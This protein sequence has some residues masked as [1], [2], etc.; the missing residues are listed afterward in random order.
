VRIIIIPGGTDSNGRRVD[1]FVVGDEHSIFAWCKIFVDQNPNATWPVFLCAT[2]E[3]QK[4][5]LTMLGAS[6]SNVPVVRPHLTEPDVDAD[7]T[8]EEL[9]EAIRIT[10]TK[11]DDK[12][13]YRIMNAVYQQLAER[14]RTGRIQ[15]KPVY[16]DDQP[17][18]LDLTLCVIG[19]DPVLDIVK[20]VGGYGGAIEEM[21]A[22]RQQEQTSGD[23]LHP[24]MTGQ[25]QDT[26]HTTDLETTLT[27]IERHA[28]WIFARHEHGA[29]NIFNKRL[30]AARND[31]ETA[32]V[33]KKD[34]LIAY[35]LVYATEGHPPP[36]TGWPLNSPYKE[37][38]RQN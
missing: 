1:D 21:L 29:R 24:E 2:A 6:G 17:S 5:R 10:L 23:R 37:R 13:P 36:T 16:L 14:I 27:P 32:G 7:G 33:S 22:Y 38:Y 18:E 11:W 34:F 15:Y 19:K 8:E 31:P 12:A 25:H 20:L 35:R 30:A 9:N 4:Q 26:E 3:S 28:E